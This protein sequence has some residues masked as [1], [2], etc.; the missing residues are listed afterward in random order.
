MQDGDGVA[1]ALNPTIPAGAWRPGD[2]IKIDTSSVMQHLCETVQLRRL[3][4]KAWIQASLAPVIEVARCGQ[5]TFLMNPGRHSVWRDRKQLGC[6]QNGAWAPLRHSH[7]RLTAEGPLSET[8]PGLNSL[9]C[10]VHDACHHILVLLAFVS[11]HAFRLGALFVR[12]LMPCQER[13]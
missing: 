8:G 11:L 7:A 13:Q 9:S 4:R 3:Q 2:Q 12:S 5:G 6:C 1:G 10:C